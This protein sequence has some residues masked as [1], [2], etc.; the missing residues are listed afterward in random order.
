[1]ETRHERRHRRQRGVLAST[2]LSHFEER[3]KASARYRVYASGNG[4]Y[5]VRVPRGLKYVVNLDPEA[6]TCECTELGEY[7]NPCKCKEVCVCCREELTLYRHAQRHTDV[8]TIK[9]TYINQMCDELRKRA[10]DEP[11]PDISEW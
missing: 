11:E 5:Q 3:L 7:Q 2:P 10:A 9:T 4:I 6:A 8:G 1:M